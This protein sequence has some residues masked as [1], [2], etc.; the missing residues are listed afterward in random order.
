MS[1]AVLV[2][3]RR[4]PVQAR[5]RGFL[6]PEVFI[7]K[8]ELNTTLISRTSH[9]D[10]PRELFNAFWG[11]RGPPSDE[12]FYP[13]FEDIWA[14]TCITNASRADAY[15]SQTRVP[16]VGSRL[17]LLPTVN[18]KTLSSASSYLTHRSLHREDCMSVLP[19]GDRK[20]E[21]HPVPPAPL[22]GR[23]HIVPALQVYTECVLEGSSSER[24]KL[25]VFKICPL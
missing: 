24:F 13:S 8:C 9:T 16:P 4:G 7:H 17:P 5:D 20:L 22:K 2:Y 10:E 15:K 11:M 25:S 18:P 1:C 14:G 6:C 23:W 3:I 21:S 19:A 12:L